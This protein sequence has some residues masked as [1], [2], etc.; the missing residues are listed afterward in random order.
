MA[1]GRL[2]TIAANFT[3]PHAYFL[4]GGVVESAPNFREWFLQK[5]RENTA[6]RSEQAQIATFAL[7]PDLDMVGARG[8][9]IAA[10]DALPAH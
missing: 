3:D 6:L 5:V 9:A 2:F 10:R 7:V 1:I 4:G 8:A